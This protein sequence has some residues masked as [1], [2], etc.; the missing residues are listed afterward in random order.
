M[1]KRIKYVY[2]GPDHRKFLRDL[3]ESKGRNLIL[4]GVVGVSTNKNILHEFGDF[5][6]TMPYQDFLRLNNVERIDY[7]NHNEIVKN[8]NMFYNRMIHGF[9]QEASPSILSNIMYSILGGLARASEMKDLYKVLNP[10]KLIPPFAESGYYIQTFYKD[11]CELVDT[12]SFDSINELVWFTM[13]FLEKTWSAWKKLTQKDINLIEKT[14][15]YIVKKKI[16]D[17][18]DAFAHEEEIL[19]MDQKLVVPRGTKIENGL[20]YIL[21]GRKDLDILM[22][23]LKQ[24]DL[25]L[26]EGEMLELEIRVENNKKTLSLAK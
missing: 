8:T 15:R 3:L 18:A 12:T 14:I 1:D 21:G 4:K 24:F 9:L 17:D 26:E 22:A 16:K 5:G 11:F 19:I 23:K 13:M 10:R 6:M 7:N 20:G 2:L 25:V